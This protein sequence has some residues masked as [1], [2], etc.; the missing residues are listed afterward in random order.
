MLHA[1]Y[2]QPS[3]PNSRVSLGKRWG[4]HLNC[5][6]VLGPLGLRIS[7]LFDLEHCDLLCYVCG[8]CCVVFAI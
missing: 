4:L 2:V 5:K 3:Q 8:F 6:L 7:F 1:L